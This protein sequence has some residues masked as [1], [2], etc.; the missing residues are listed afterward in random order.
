MPNRKSITALKFVLY[1]IFTSFAQENHP[2]SIVVPA[3]QSTTLS[4][5]ANDRKIYIS[6]L[7]LQ[8]D[9]SLKELLPV[10]TDIFRKELT[11]TGKFK[12]MAREMM[13]QIIQEKEFQLTDICDQAS[14]LT[15]AGLIT[16]VSEIVA[17][18]VVRTGKDSYVVA[19]KLVDV[20][21]GE[22]L[23]QGNEQLSGDTY[24]IIKRMLGNLASV[25]AGK[26][27]EDHLTIENK[28]KQDIRENKNLNYIEAARYSI[29]IKSTGG[30]P[31][32]LVQK[33]NYLAVKNSIES[34][35]T[36]GKPQSTKFKVPADNFTFGTEAVLKYKFSPI[37]SLV[38][39]A[40]FSSNP[41]L[42]KEAVT[43]YNYEYSLTTGSD[44]VYCS[45]PVDNHSTSWHSYN[46]TAIGIG[47]S[48]R[49]MKSPHATFSMDIIPECGYVNYNVTS[50]DSS[51]WNLPIYVNGTYGGQIQLYDE[52]LKEANLH[53]SLFGG[54]AGF[55][56]NF[57]PLHWIGLQTSASFQTLVALNLEGK[58]KVSEV[59]INRNT[60]E[61]Q[62]TT[63]TDDAAM[64]R[65]NW[66]GTGDFFSVQ[67]PY[68][69]YAGHDNK[70]IHAEKTWF[71]FSSLRFTIGLIILF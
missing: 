45:G 41:K 32:H 69:Q 12:V 61:I 56:I 18:S 43:A 20:A 26:Q 57:F 15:K 65:G 53:S 23:Q 40:E 51:F 64:M 67:N 39:E 6:V 3:I 13:E 7:P 44:T 8:G 70:P 58:E 29:D 46:L 36:S 34:S 50:L 28:V 10:F 4:A 48:I 21:T 33:D 25:L 52:A 49:I 31:L 22:L 47:T 71:E 11:N 5:S 59:H 60:N 19:A 54:R 9:S 42:K 68:I 2:D 62:D 16:G 17:G 24:T 37:F 14:C 38:F 55:T 30:Y 66:L 27:N 1:L 63:Y 35:S